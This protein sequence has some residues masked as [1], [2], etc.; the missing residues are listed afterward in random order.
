[1]P[2]EGTEEIKNT[3]LSFYPDQ[4]GLKRF[5]PV[6]ESPTTRR[7]GRNDVKLTLVDGTISKYKSF[8]RDSGMR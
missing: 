5:T 7:T 3:I 6:S 4:Q 2:Y 8:V 1:M